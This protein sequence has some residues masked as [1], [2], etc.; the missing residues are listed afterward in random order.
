MRYHKFASGAGWAY[1]YGT[2]DDSKEMFYYLKGY[3]PV[4]NVKNGTEYPATLIKVGD[5]DDRLVPGHSFK[6]VSELQEKYQ[7][8][9][10]VLI[11]I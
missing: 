2:S 3:S 7:G 9:N 4:Q 6:F 11:R 8:Q 5:H 1:D 10:L